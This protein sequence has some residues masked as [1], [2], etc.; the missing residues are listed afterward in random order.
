MTVES[1]PLLILHLMA[2][3]SLIKSLE[4]QRKS[5]PL[6]S[7]ESYELLHDLEI[8]ITECE[9]MITVISNE[10]ETKH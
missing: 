6:K 2:F 10:L 5:M 9:N 8:N 3:I 4:L 1:K 7:K